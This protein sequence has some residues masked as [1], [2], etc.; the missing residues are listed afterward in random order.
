MKDKY[1]NL[2]ELLGEFIENLEKL[3]FEA[4]GCNEG[5]SIIIEIKHKEGESDEI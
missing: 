4:Y 5:G 3:G 1:D 2:E